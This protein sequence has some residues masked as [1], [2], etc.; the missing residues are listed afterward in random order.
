[1]RLLT[2]LFVR[3]D[4]HL[5]TC[6]ADR[7]YAVLLQRCFSEVQTHKLEATGG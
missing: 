7:E 3:L 2:R 1:M 5:C 6:N 4:G